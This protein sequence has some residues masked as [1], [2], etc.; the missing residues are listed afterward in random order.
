MKVYNQPSPTDWPE[1]L[2]RPQLDQE[3]LESQVQDIIATIKR[4]GDEG[5]RYYS[6]IFDPSPVTNFLAS[7]EELEAQANLVPKELKQAIDLAATNIQRFHESQQETVQV[8][9]TSPG[10]RCWRK[11]VAIEKVGLYIPGGSAPLFSSFLMLLVPA[12]IAGCPQ[13]VVSTPPNAQGSVEPTVAYIAQKFGIASVFK[14]G[15]AQAIAAM[16]YGTETIPSVYKVLGPGNQYVT[17]AKQLLQR[18]GLCIDM[19][20]GPSEVLVIADDSAN[21]AFVAADLLSQAEHGSDSQVILCTPSAGLAQAVAQETATQLAELPRKD[22][23]SQSLA[24]SKILVVED[25]TTC[26]NISNLY[27]PEHLII[28]TKSPEKE[29]ENVL[30]AG[31]VFLGNYSCETAG[32]YASGTNHTLPTNGCARAYSGVSL[33]SFVKKITFQQLSKEGLNQLAPTLQTLA[34]AEKLDAHARAVA[35]RLE[36]PENA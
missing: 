3:Q 2:K 11:S 28:A 4:D 6:R 12:L 31:S 20:A 34:R 27:A 1:L 25:L 13:I 24:H 22:I 23:A 33:D 17:A 19:P 26:F 8:V 10:V 35:I 7:A 36:N 29:A 14:T 21:P 32:D 18:E 30:N 16:T 15:G 5:L 9:E